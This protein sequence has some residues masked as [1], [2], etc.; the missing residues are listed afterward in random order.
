[1]SCNVETLEHDMGE[2][3]W[4]VD[5]Y[6]DQLMIQTMTQPTISPA[7]KVIGSPKCGKLKGKKRVRPP[8]DRL[9]V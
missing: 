7:K 4:T 5:P 3:E 2:N 6:G 8:P 9:M 1:M